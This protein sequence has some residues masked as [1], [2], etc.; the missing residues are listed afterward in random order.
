MKT[1]QV[2]LQLQS[3]LPILS[4]Y[5]S[6]RLTIDSV[7]KSGLVA[8]VETASAH[9]LTTG[10]IVAIS[11]ILTPVEVDSFVEGDTTVT[12]NFVTPHDLTLNANAPLDSGQTIFI[13]GN[14]DG[15]FSATY[16]LVGVPNRRSV[17]VDTGDNPPVPDDIIL[18]FQSSVDY[19]Y[20]GL[21]TILSTP[22]PTSFTYAIDFDLPEPNYTENE[23]FL[24]T[25]PRIS[26]AVDIETV[27]RSYTEQANE[28]VWAFVILGSFA[29]N[30]DRLNQ[31]DATTTQ[32]RQSDF[33]QKIISNFSI[34]IL[35]PNKG[36]ILTKTNGRAARDLVED[37]RLPIFRSILGVDLSADLYAQGQG[38]ITY[39]GD[40]P[41]SYDGAVYVHEFKFQQV[42]E[43]TSKDTAIRD[44][45]RAFRD[46]SMIQTNQFDELSIY[47]ASIDLDDEPL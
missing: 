45:D 31:N 23:P 11:G 21:K 1:E 3:R 18:S 29:A 17:V 35:V 8:T 43:I 16:D 15:T 20:N 38:I 42:I 32:G 14:S 13:F 37:V 40:A 28:A 22:T 5:F 26:G 30:N 24:C 47:T 33:R 41:V 9:R 10:D 27:I 19:G 39:N 7:T 46:I 12:F 6:N 44:F 36:D 4:P 25:S 34:F 2:I